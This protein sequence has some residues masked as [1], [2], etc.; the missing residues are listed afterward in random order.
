MKLCQRVNSLLPA[1]QIMSIHTTHTG[2]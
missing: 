1:R 2:L